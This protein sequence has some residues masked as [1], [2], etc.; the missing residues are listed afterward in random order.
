MEFNTAVN[1]SEVRELQEVGEAGTFYT[2]GSDGHSMF[3]PTGVCCLAPAP[4]SH[5][6]NMEHLQKRDI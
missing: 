3:P 4:W 5:V 2:E 6:F 1:R